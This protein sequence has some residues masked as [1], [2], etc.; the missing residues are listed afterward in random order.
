MILLVSSVVCLLH[1]FL[2]IVPLEMETQTD[3]PNELFDEIN[4]SINL[5][6]I[7]DVPPDA[8]LKTIRKRIGSLFLEAQ[9][10]L[11]HRNFRRRFYYR[12]LTEVVLP[13]ARHNLLD[14]E[15]REDYNLSLGVAAPSTPSL[16]PDS[17]PSD[18]AG[19]LTEYSNAA[20]AGTATSAKNMD[21]I[22]VCNGHFAE[23]SEMPP[24][25]TNTNSAAA[26]R[27]VAARGTAVRGVTPHHLKMDAGQV[28]RRR[29]FKR[30]ELIKQELVAVGTRW[31]VMVGVLAFALSALLLWGAGVTLRVQALQ[32]AALPIALVCAT[33]CARSAHRKAR[34][35]VI[36]LLSKM[37]Y[38]Q[39][40]QRCAKM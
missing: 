32:L 23:Q 22:A 25:A 10:N 1:G 39:L 18:S 6:E 35:S 24:G 27:S 36:A 5:Y 8:D 37:P 11:D 21:G 30:R 26:D 15:R 28:E 14:A 19:T 33:F 13:R 4:G 7:L 17:L 2:M 29:D 34:K 12:E 31:A 40:L 16:S 9:N 3:A 38:E 20:D